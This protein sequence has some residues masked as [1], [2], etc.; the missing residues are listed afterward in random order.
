MSR[1]TAAA[2]AAAAA[3]GELR[4]CVTQV[5][6]KLCY[7]FWAIVLLF[8]VIRK[9]RDFELILG[10]QEAGMGCSSLSRE[11]GLCQ[12]NCSCCFRAFPQNHQNAGTHLVSPDTTGKIKDH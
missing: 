5:R 3:V 4:E 8:D 2:T 12:N 10:H 7:C 9:S 6:Q 11:T 1:G